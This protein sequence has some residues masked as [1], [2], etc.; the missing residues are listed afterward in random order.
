MANA[1]IPRSDGNKC[2]VYVVGDANRP[3]VVVLQEAW[4][5][6]EQIKKVADRFAEAGFRALIPDLYRGKVANTLDEAMHLVRDLDWKSAGLDLH[7]AVDYLKKNGSPTV[8]VTGFCLG[9]SL[10]LYALATVPGFSAGAP[11]YGI[12]GDEACDVSKIKVPF[13][14]HYAQK[15]KWCTV[16]KVKALEEKLHKAGFTD[17]AI[18]FYDADH[19]FA[20]ESRPEVYDAKATQA[21]FDRTFTFFGAVLCAHHPPHRHHH[22][23]H[24]HHPHP[25]PQHLEHAPEA[26]PT[27]AQ[28]T[29]QP[30]QPQQ[31]QQPPAK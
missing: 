26:H 30:Q 20:N 16:E 24:H 14:G 1:E 25:H 9:G 3:A 28:G 19:A 21:A 13:I 11:F 8:G 4:G 22:H 17:F 7:A 10:T 15:D 23:H 29:Q 2:P 31:S 5:L 12:P 6:N 18:H 27:P